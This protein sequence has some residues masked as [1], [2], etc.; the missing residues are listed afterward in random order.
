M[1]NY[2]ITIGR[3]VGS[4][5]SV[6]GR[7][8]AEHFGFNY[9]DKDLVKK[10][11]KELNS[12]EED[13][14]PLDEKETLANRLLLQTGG[15]PRAYMSDDWKT[16][17][18]EDLFKTESKIIRQSAERASCVVVGRCGFHLFRGYERHIS[19]F[20]YSDEEQR[21][22]RLSKHLGMADEKALKMM[23]KLD[24]ERARYVHTYTGSAWQDPTNY[25]LT[26]DTAKLDDEQLL[27]LAIH[28]IC[29]RFPELEK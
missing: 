6:L 3:Q 15:Y 18:G 19:L 27:E 10:A 2:V 23:R 7:S 20:L 26:I 13:L 9:I 11:A 24:K 29:N 22:R 4:G 16:F 8:L 28:Y 25:D 17:T 5:G 12:P 14:A 1:N 21:I